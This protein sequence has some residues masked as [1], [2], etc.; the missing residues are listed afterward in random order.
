MMPSPV[1]LPHYVFRMRLLL[2]KERTATQATGGVK[3]P[4]REVNVVLLALMKLVMN[5]C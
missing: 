2:A 5:S 1:G 3:R 4:I